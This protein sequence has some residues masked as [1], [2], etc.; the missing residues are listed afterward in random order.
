S[1]LGKTMVRGGC[2][3]CPLT[4][5]VGVVDDVRYSGLAG[6][7][8]SMHSPVTEDWPSTLVLFVRTAAAPEQLAVP[9]RDALRSVDPSVPLD[10]VATMEERLY[11]AVAPPRQ[12]AT[13]LGGF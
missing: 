7:L 3:D 8:E 1:P 6:P 4:T 13:L 12:W 2:T 5:I 11:T 10:D 9:V